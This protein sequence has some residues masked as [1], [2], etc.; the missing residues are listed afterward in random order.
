[1]INQIKISQNHNNGKKPVVNTAKLA[2]GGYFNSTSGQ[3]VFCKTCDSKSITFKGLTKELSNHLYSTRDQVLSIVDR[4]KAK[5][6]GLVG[7]M[8]HTWIQK[9]PQA[10]KNESIKEVYSVFASVAKLLGDNSSK[11]K[12]AGELLA[13]IL[14]KSG[15][16]SEKDC[17]N[18]EFINYGSFGSAYLLEIPVEGN[19]ERYVLKI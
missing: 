4:F 15:I 17:L 13:N 18:L 9:I 1:M 2:R 10:N 5:N 12:E 14:R 8:P 6:N 11:T 3:D 7:S 16:I 19:L